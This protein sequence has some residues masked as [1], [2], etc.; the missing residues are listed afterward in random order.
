MI[1]KK[2]LSNSSNCIYYMNQAADNL[3]KLA[4]LN[5]FKHSPDLVVVG[6]T[7]FSLYS[8]KETDLWE[9]TSAELLLNVG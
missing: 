5:Y 7:L 3:S 9:D 2:Q 1:L 6:G 8:I 4:K